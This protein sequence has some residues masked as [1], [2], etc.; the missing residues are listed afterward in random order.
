[1]SFGSRVV[2]FTAVVALLASSG[3]AAAAQA[4]A[5][6]EGFHAR[7][8]LVSGGTDQGR[9]LAGIEIVLDPGFKTYWRNPGESGLPPRFDWDGSTNAQAI[10]LKWPVPERTEDPAGVSFGYHDRVT[11]PVVVRP[12]KPGEP[13]RLA[14]SVDYGVC[15]DICIPAHAELALTLSGGEDGRPLVKE[16]LDAVPRPQALA[17]P[18]DL[19]ILG[20]TPE[21]GDATVFRVGVRSPDGSKPELFAEAPEGWYLST[22]PAPGGGFLIKV[23]ERPKDAKGPVPV[24]L[25]LAAGDRAVETGIRLAAPP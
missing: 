12:G 13:V 14:V 15:R 4:S 18:G 2:E 24:T 5:W 10:D 3:G 16:A 8:R 25:T 7:A 1:M 23:E 9:L 19:S 11:F 20:V 22:G 21:P 6:D 17:A